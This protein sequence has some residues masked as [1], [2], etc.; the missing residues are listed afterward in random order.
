MVHYEPLISAEINTTFQKTI[1]VVVFSH[2]VCW[3][4]GDRPFSSDSNTKSFLFPFYFLLNSIRIIE[5]FPQKFLRHNLD[6][7]SLKKKEERKKFC[8]GTVEVIRL[9]V[10][11]MANLLGLYSSGLE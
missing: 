10:A 5:P 1:W 4:S 6:L 2:T 3:E 11:A 8:G 7:E 9:V